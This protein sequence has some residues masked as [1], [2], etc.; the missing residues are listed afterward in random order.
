MR[1][2]TGSDGV[3]RIRLLPPRPGNPRNSEGAFLA[4]NDGRVLFVYTHFTGGARDDSAAHLAS[5]ESHDGGFTWSDEDVLVVLNEGGC[6]VMSVSLVRL[7]DDRIALFYLRKNSRQ[8]CRPYVRFSDD[9]AGTWSGP[10]PCIAQPGYYVLNND[11]VVLLPSGRLVA[12]VCHHPTESHRGPGSGIVSC[13]LSDD[14]GRTWRR[15]R[16]ALT[17]EVTLQEPGVVRLKDGRLFMFIR[18]DTGRQY[19][20]HS[21]DEG[22][23]WSPVAPSGIVSP[24]S[25]ASVKRIPQAGDLLLVW[26]ENYEP[27]KWHCGR[28]TPLRVAISRDEARTWEKAKTL[29]SDPEKWYCYTAIH[30]V[31][32]NVLL[33][34]CAGDEC[35]GRLSA[36]QLTVF[37][38]EWLYT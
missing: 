12:P 33:A 7:P 25:P 18:T 19:V 5:R 13:L 29:E 20:S 2:I 37:P 16:S 17:S 31:G 4:L 34:H 9:E 35:I 3:T 15:S 1:G 30:F 36:T 22:E 6:N 8:D 24:L 38:V 11:R 26:N 21:A 10:V 32:D 14:G 28:R 27:G 23:T